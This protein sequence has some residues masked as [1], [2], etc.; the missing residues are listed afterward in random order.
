[1]LKTG[2]SHA[3][4]GLCSED[5]DSS[6]AAWEQAVKLEPDNVEY[7]LNLAAVSLRTSQTKESREAVSKLLDR[8]SDLWYDSKHRQRYPELAAFRL[9]IFAVHQAMAENPEGA[10]R[11]VAKIL[12]DH[13]DDVQAQGLQRFL[14]ETK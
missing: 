1:M 5:P 11:T 7:L 14:Q 12:E 6:R 2:R 3:L 9:R 13:P 8:V 4:I 10:L